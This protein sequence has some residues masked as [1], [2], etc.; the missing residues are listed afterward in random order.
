MFGSRFGPPRLR[1]RLARANDVGDSSSCFARHLVGPDSHDLPSIDLQP[2]VG[3]AVANLI[4]DDLCAPELG[5]L[6]GTGRKSWAAVPEAPIDEDGDPR[7]C[8]GQISNPAR[9]SRDG[10]MDSEAQPDGMLYT[11]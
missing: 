8:Q 7:A 3:I 1:L 6:L 10:H 4:R 11:Q 5:V 9:I 2:C